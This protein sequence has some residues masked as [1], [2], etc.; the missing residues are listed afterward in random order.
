MKHVVAGKRVSFTATAVAI[1][2]VMAIARKDLVPPKES[3][4]ASLIDSVTMEKLYAT[5]VYFTHCTYRIKELRT[6][7][8]Q[9]VILSCDLPTSACVCQD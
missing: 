1:V 9:L 2:D 8:A 3:G 4:V 6:R 5:H 7:F